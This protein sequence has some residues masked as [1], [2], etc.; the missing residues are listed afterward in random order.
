MQLFM[1]L[2][3]MVHPFPIKGTKWN[4]D[5]RPDLCACDV[6]APRARFLRSPKGRLGAQSHRNASKGLMLAARRAGN[7]Q[8]RKPTAASR[9]TTAP[10]LS[11]SK[12][13]T[14]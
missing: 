3:V 12:G 2:P 11:G 7:Q 4:H 8:A 9:P 6:S 10:K 5:D 14:S 1:V 13:E